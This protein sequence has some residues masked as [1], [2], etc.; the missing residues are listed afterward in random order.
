MPFHPPLI[1]PVL[2]RLQCWDRSCLLLLKSAGVAIGAVVN[3]AG[4]AV[5]VHDGGMSMAVFDEIAG[6]AVCIGA[7]G[8]TVATTLP[9]RLCRIVGRA[10]I[11]A[12]IAP[13]TAKWGGGGGGGVRL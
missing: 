4:N 10:G 1:G 5:G 8:S 7:G 3:V 2:L 6:N 11:T 9:A 13:K 12:G